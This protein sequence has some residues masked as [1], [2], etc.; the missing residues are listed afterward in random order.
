MGSVGEHEIDQISGEERV[1]LAIAFGLAL[2]QVLLGRVET[3]ITGEPM[4]HLDEE[5]RKE[6]VNVL[7]S[8]FRE[9]G[10]IVP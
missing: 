8:F 1:A 3:I 4:T 7:S 5:R 2:A 6:L 10:R 9:G